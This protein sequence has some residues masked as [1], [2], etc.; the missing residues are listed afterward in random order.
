MSGEITELVKNYN[1]ELKEVTA[2][3]KMIDQDHK[4]LGYIADGL[5]SEITAEIRASNQ[6]VTD[7]TKVAAA[8]TSSIP[9]V[10][11]AT[12]L[13]DKL[14]TIYAKHSSKISGIAGELWNKLD[15]NHPAQLISAD[16]AQLA[17]QRMQRFTEIQNKYV[18]MY[19]D[20]RGQQISIERQIN[21]MGP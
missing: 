17:D 16:M 19:W 8:A 21:S 6:A 18:P 9:G 11:D 3:D 10:K 1:Q 14:A 12:N 4:A 15:G 5:K 13:A 7:A 2:L 20:L